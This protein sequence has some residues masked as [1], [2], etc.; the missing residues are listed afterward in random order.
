MSSQ[1]RRPR[2]GAPI[3]RDKIRVGPAPPS[4]FE[5]LESVTAAVPADIPGGPV[6]GEGSRGWH[7][8]LVRDAKNVPSAREAL[9]NKKR[10]LQEEL[11]EVEIPLNVEPPHEIESAV[12]APV[13]VSQEAPRFTAEFETKLKSVIDRDTAVVKLPKDQY[14]IPSNR[15][16]FKQFI[17]QTYR[18]YMLP[19]LSAIPDPEACARA[20]ATSKEVKTFSYQAF[21]R[22]FIQ[23]PSPY[24]GI[25]VYHGLGSGK[26]CTSIASMEVLYNAG[27]K[28]IYIFTPASLSKNYRDEITK[29]G[30]FIFRPNNF[31]KWVS[32]PN[33]K[34]KT[35][36][37]E[38]LI[39]VLGIPVPVIR[40]QK[41]AWVPDPTKK[42]NL[43]SLSED[44]K[45]QIMSQIY[46]HIDY[47]FQFIHYNG[48]LEKTVRDWACNNPTMFD[49]ATI[50]IDE[51]HN[52]IRTI[53]NSN[54]EGLYKDEPRN[55]P[56]Y[57]PKYC[58]VGRKYKIS[59]LLYRMLCSSVGCKI[60]ALSGTPI[61]N[62]PQEI[63][64]LANILAG[65]T[66]MAEAMIPGMKSQAQMLEYLQRHPEVDFAEVLPRQ[67]INASIVRITPVPSGCS[68]IIDETTG[69]FRGFVRDETKIGGTEEMARERD[70]KSWFARVAGDTGLSDAKF[71]SV[72]RL[73]DIEKNFREIFVDTENL[74]IKDTMKIPLEARLSG[75][76]SY[77]KGG[78]ADLMA[79]VTKDEVVML[80]MSDLQLKEYTAMRK[81]EIDKEQREQKRKKP[82][83]AGQADAM[84]GPSMYDMVTKGQS[85]TFKIFS[86]AACN[87]SFPADMDRPRPAD[88]REAVKA[89]GLAEEDKAA[90][91]S[92]A[93]AGEGAEEVPAPENEIVVEEGAKVSQYEL[94]I[95]SSVNE[96][97]TR[98]DEFFSKDTL[99]TYSPKFQAIIDRMQIM[100]S[101]QSTRGPVLLYSQFKALEGVT[102][103]SV[104]IE[105][106][107]K[108]RKFDIEPDGVGGWRLT[109]ETKQ[110]GPGIKRYIT[111]TG[112]E[113]S[114]KRNILKAVFNAAW[115]KLPA[116][117]S[118]E[119]RTL[120]GTSN[121]Q[122]G[123]IVKLIMITQS[124]AEGISL[125]NVRQVHIME[126]YWNYVRLE[127]VKG[128]AIRIC[129]HD[130]LPY[131]ER[132][133]DVFTYISRFGKA[134]I[135]KRLVDETLLNFDRGQ[136]TD[137][138]ILV[139]SNAKK[140]LADSIFQVMQESAVDCELNA[141]ENGTIGCFRLAKDAGMEPLFHPI[142]SVHVGNMEG[143][144]RATAA[145]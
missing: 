138:S 72:E 118:E 60:V 115:N 40:K 101:K 34:I 141:T 116:A 27:Q 24:R 126:P 123:D 52:L 107:M 48:L 114:E 66:R 98:A 9:G 112:D 30:P 37:A 4:I 61:I 100:D 79:R 31:W 12:S 85:S 25:L 50:I 86:R 124:G 129:S 47:R 77:Y 136:T 17:I 95:R 109:A 102:L 13:E 81:E 108:F 15:R 7:D 19:P 8:K 139:L 21:V 142:V 44:Q 90:A 80:D 57:S 32:I 39:N 88:F 51:V 14:Y 69:A 3:A 113:K 26:T 75:L 84:R 137:E 134:Q 29:C 127:Q 135:E 106:Q 5:M 105:H 49:G 82:V 56:Q 54:L 11:K 55:A 128:R 120:T 63:A 59:Y 122:K 42:S 67:D 144:I 65:D 104:A 16:A 35:E 43:D 78:K 10:V 93:A 45:A 103:F 94:A 121:N 143:T 99:P 89:L 1:I 28:P 70:L 111:Y 133:V 33:M 41:G 53:N 6:V 68:K 23:K 74:K 2:F 132:T 18:R 46:A 131:E 110:A 62:Y 76:I 92:S 91:A 38:F 73:P 83:A 125:S 97:R 145:R 119:I 117:L 20:K 22:D 87:F 130:E 96:L 36:E 71:I 140:K 64:I 58:A